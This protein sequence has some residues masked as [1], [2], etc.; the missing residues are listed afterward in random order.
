[1]EKELIKRI[2]SHIQHNDFLKKDDV[3]VILKN[4][5]DLTYT[6]KAYR[7]LLFSN[8]TKENSLEDDLS[9]SKNLSSIKFYFNQQDINYYK[10]A[11]IYEVEI[12]GLDLNKTVKQ[13]K[14]DHKELVENEEEIIAAKL[15][16]QDLLINDK[17][18]KVDIFLNNY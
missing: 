13:F 11:Q 4:Y 17:S 10:H 5:P 9:F 3:L 8:P 6:G 16:K 7:V 1:M 15:Y 18:E 14:L 2:E 12:L